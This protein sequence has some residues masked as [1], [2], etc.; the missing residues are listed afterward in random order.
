MAQTDIELPGDTPAEIG[1]GPG[2]YTISAF[3]GSGFWLIE[4]AGQ[5]VSA[6]GHLL[7]PQPVSMSLEANEVLYVSG[8]GKASI[9]GTFTGDNG[10]IAD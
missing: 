3:N 6:K 10:L 5:T 1:S 2:V 7:G 4:A 8:L 9:T